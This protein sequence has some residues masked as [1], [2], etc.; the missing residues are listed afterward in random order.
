MVMDELVCKAVLRRGTAGWEVAAGL[1]TAVQ[2]VPESLRHMVEQ[3]LGQ[4]SST[5]QALLEAASVEGI[6]FSATAIAAAVDEMDEAVEARCDALARREQF[7]RFQSV[8][9]W[10]DGTIT[11]QYAF[12][13]ALFQ[14]ILYE[15]VP[16]SRRVRWQRQIGSR[17]D[18]SYDPPVRKPGA[19][20][21]PLTPH[22]RQVIRSR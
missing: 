21:E 1:E 15:R 17:L 6:E 22:R 11:T 5:D 7:L 19:L 16:V 13:H 2:G 3:Q 12:L 14:Q 20:L 18:L 8:L 10:P 4:L 9:S